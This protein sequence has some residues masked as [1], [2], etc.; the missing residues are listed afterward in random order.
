MRFFMAW[1]H[2]FQSTVWLEAT[3][4]IGDSPL[5]IA[6]YLLRITRV[7]VLLSVWRLIYAGRAEASGLTL[8]GVLTYTLLAE[9]FREPLECRGSG[10]EQALWDGSISL[11]LLRPFGIFSQFAALKIGGWLFSLVFFS[12]PLLL[13]APVLGVNPLPAYGHLAVFF[14]FSLLLAIL[15]GLALEF[16]LAAFMVDLAHNL[17]AI[18]RIREIVITVFSG[19]L[20]PLALMPWGIG[21]VFAWLPFAAMASIPLQIYVGTI[22]P[23][24]GA[25]VQLVWNLILWPLAFRL[26]QRRRERLVSHGG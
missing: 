7:V 26:W 25:G 18:Q 8:A 2:K 20:L 13:A 22:H 14:L 10:L 6:D 1:F 16:I 11:C 15:V 19:T 12:L 3:G 21:S 4:R 5:F 9:V 17:Y 24:T 23:L